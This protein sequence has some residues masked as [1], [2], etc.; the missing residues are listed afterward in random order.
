[1]D[2]VGRTT[3]KLTAVNLSDGMRGRELL[4]TYD[5]PLFTGLRKP[6][7]VSIGMMGVFLTAYAIGRLDVSIGKKQQ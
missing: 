5:Y 7:T 4:V 2:T 1:M 6:L 3:L